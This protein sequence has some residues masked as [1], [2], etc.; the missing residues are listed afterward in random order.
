MRRKS[1]GI[2]DLYEC[3]YMNLIVTDK[4]KKIRDKK[5]K[6][7]VRNPSRIEEEKK[8]S[9]REIKSSLGTLLMKRAT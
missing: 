3:C 5:K 1:L 9:S 2:P 8:N 7:Q 4:N 6:R